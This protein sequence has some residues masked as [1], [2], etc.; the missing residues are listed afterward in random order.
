[1]GLY[2]QLPMVTLVYNLLLLLVDGL[3]VDRLARAEPG[4]RRGVVVSNGLRLGIVA[5]LLA[6]ALGTGF[7]IVGLMAWA[8]FLHG[9]LLSAAMAVVLWRP[10]RALAWW[11][12][13][14]AVLLPAIAVDAFLVE[15]F[16][17]EV[18]RFEVPAPGLSRPLRIGVLADFQTD[19]IGAYER[20]ALATLVAEKP[21]LVLLP[22]D[23]LQ[24]A[25]A[26]DLRRLGAQ[27]RQVMTEIGFGPPLGTFAVQGN[28]ENAGWEST[29][30][31]LPVVATSTTRTVELPELAITL[32]SL[33]DSFDTTLAITRR[34]GFHVVV[35]HAPD[36]AL[37]RVEADLL[38]AGHTHGGQ[39][40]IPGFGPLVT[41]SRVP[42]RWA[43]GGLTRLE[44]GRTLVVSRGVGLERAGAPPLRFFCRPQLI[45]L[46][47]VPQGVEE[48]GNPSAG[49]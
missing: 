40:Q 14:A 24:V 27:L 7:G 26:E 1:M 45:V 17:L 16:R 21:D 39:V 34:Q 6:L 35:G 37:G 49:P 48:T 19:E 44:G 18:S 28:V 43:A 12:L 2:C 42:R 20:R 11:P 4:R 22:G 46:E 32:L 10:A 31:G 25:G 30:G 47:L 8:I 29:F 9:T 23:Y 38:V 13:A 41:L 33:R 15:P 5:Q 36:F 3:L